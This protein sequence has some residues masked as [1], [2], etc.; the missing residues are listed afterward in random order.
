MVSPGPDQPD[1]FEHVSVEVFGGD[2]VSV[3]VAAVIHQRD[4]GRPAL[5]NLVG[6]R[7]HL[8]KRAVD[9]LGTQVAVE[10]E[11]AGLDLVKRCAQRQHH[12]AHHRLGA[13]LR[14]RR[15]G[16]LLFQGNLADL[17]FETQFLARLPHQLAGARRPLVRDQQLK[18]L[19]YADR[20]FD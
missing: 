18:L 1:P 12:A 7:P 4:E 3:G 16:G 10:Q 2:L 9:E 13:A 20:A 6:Q 15:C 8:A 14:L 17:E 11:D 5:G 19:G